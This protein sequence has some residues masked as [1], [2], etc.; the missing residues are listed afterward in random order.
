M[1]QSLFFVILLFFCSNSMASDRYITVVT[2][3]GNSIIDPTTKLTV[4]GTGKGLFE[5]NVV[6]RFEDLQGNLLLQQS[7]I[8]QRE[9]IA[10]AG[11]WQLSISLPQSVPNSIRLIAFSPSPKDGEMA[12]ASPPILLDVSGG[13]GRSLV[14]S[15]WRLNQYLNESGELQVTN[16]DTVIDA[17]FADGKL[18][19]GGGCNRYFGNYTLG[20]N[21]QLLFDGP[22]GSTQM[23]CAQQIASQEQ[24]YLALLAD[25]YRWEIKGDRLLLLN[26]QG[27]PVLQYRAE[28]PLTL[29][30]SHWQAAGIN[31]GR[32]GVVSSAITTQVNAAFVDNKISG[33]SGCN[34]YSASYET[35]DSQITI[36]PV[37]TT[38]RQCDQPEGIMTQEQEFLQALAVTTQYKLTADKLELRDKNGS[39][40]VGFTR[41]I[42]LQ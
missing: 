41:P 8:I 40:Q 2:P 37:M 24:R 21:N 28:L 14:G 16:V 3:N 1:R 12:I 23:A 35:S 26:N 31:N 19:G 7:T 42:S 22:I 38:R 9:N 29:V 17:Q 4:S 20:P 34:R 15:Q 30:N 18:S 27:Q 39:L 13:A 10:A 32:G 5:G 33:S 36:G 11:K 25:V 6:V